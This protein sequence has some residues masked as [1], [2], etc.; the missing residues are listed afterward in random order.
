MD[1]ERRA[2]RKVETVKDR[3]AAGQPAAVPERAIRAGGV[4]A[5]WAWTEP[6]VWTER[7]LAALE[8]GVRGGKWYSLMDKG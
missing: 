2:G 6:P 8:E 7:R 3:Q 5:R 1:V 4:R